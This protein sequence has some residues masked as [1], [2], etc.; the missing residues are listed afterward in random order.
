MVLYGLGF[1]VIFLVLLLL[2]YHAYRK[3]SALELT[4]LETFDAKT[5]IM[6]HFLS[7][8]VGLFSISLAVF[9]GQGMLSFSGMSY[10][11]LG[12][13]HGT[14]G[15]IYGKR[16]QQLEASLKRGNGFA[17]REFRVEDP[18]EVRMLNRPKIGFGLRL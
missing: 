9:G 5:G 1:I 10:A 11:L 17:S 4:E 8:L 13:V 16:R 15:C 7:I 18:P 6:F 14:A 2:Y 12:P 3:R